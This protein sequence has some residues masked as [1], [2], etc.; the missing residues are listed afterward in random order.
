MGREEAHGGQ[1]AGTVSGQ[2]ATL[3][4]AV[5]ERSYG[6]SAESLAVLRVLADIIVPAVDGCPAASEVQA[7]LRAA[8]S[9]EMSDEARSL[10]SLA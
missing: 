4:E 9:L 6:V 2:A 5:L 1:A 3:D 8:Q 7:H 10:C